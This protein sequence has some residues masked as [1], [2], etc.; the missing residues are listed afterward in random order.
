MVRAKRSKKVPTARQLSDEFNV[1]TSNIYS[2]IKKKSSKLE[3][4][5]TVWRYRRLLDGMNDS[6]KRAIESVV[7]DNSV[8]MKNTGMTRQGISSAKQKFIENRMKDPNDNYI[9]LEQYSKMKMIEKHIAD[10]CNTII[11]KADM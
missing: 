7:V 4:Y 2:L 9:L 8:L 3:Q 5:E 11:N 1:G 10:N 6:Q